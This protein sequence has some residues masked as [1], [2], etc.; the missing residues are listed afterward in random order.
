MVRVKSV[1]RAF[2]LVLL[3]FLISGYVPVEAVQPSKPMTGNRQGILHL[4]FDDDQAG[5]SA[6]SCVPPAWTTELSD[7]LPKTADYASLNEST[8]ALT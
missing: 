7:E 1:K 3:S 4:V 5:I 8:A 6:I 2:L